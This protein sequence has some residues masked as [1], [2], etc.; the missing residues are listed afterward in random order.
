MQ[1]SPTFCKEVVSIIQTCD[2]P[3]KNNL[4]V[5][6]NSYSRIKNATK[7]RTCIENYTYTKKSELN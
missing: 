3:I 6:I 5:T 2:I 1:F 4:T 7:V